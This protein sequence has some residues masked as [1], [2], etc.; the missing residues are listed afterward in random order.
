MLMKRRTRLLIFAG[1]LASLGAGV[2]WSFQYI[3]DRW[4]PWAPLGF[5]DAPNILTAHKLRRLRTDP[6]QCRALLAQSS[7][8]YVE[9]ADRDLGKG[10]A[11]TN[12][13]QVSA[14]A[15]AY[16]SRFTASCPIAASLALFERHVL[17]P[18]AQ[19]I[20]AQPVARIEHLGSYACR[21]VN[22]RTE[23]RL[24]EHANANAIDLSAFVLKDGTR[25]AVR[26]DWP[27]P[28]AEEEMTPK[29]KFLR[30]IHKGACRYF[31]SVLGPD[32]NSA[33]RDHFH[34]DMGR[35]S[36]CR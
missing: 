32:Y 29:G 3:P 21:N 7:L 2:W 22:N 8:K 1:L 19:S 23:G 36:I 13:V 17:Q 25:I 31:K 14:S 5:D 6:A 27:R 10:C 26:T 34:A 28:V 18:A 35:Y 20:F 11:F 30:E 9:V 15:V 24:S 12:A 16:N 4:N 33:H